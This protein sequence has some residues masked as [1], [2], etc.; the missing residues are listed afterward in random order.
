MGNT[1]SPNLVANG[2]CKVITSF[3]NE[4]IKKKELRDVVDQGPSK[5]RRI[6]TLTAIFFQDQCSCSGKQPTKQ[7][8]S[9]S[10]QISMSYVMPQRKGDKGV[11][12]AARD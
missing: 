12:Q 4:K 7:G 3:G 11:T 9:L 5:S 6:K 1:T 10:K 8:L 2:E